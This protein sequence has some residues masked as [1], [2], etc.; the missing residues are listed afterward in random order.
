MNYISNIDTICILLDIE[1]YEESAKE[2]LQFLSDEKEKAKLTAI[3]NASQKHLVT[4]N[5]MNFE[6]RAN[7]TRGYAYILHNSGYSVNISQIKSKIDSFVPI[8]IRISSEYL[9]SNGLTKSWGI[10]Y[11]W[12]I[13]TFGNIISEKVYRV[14]LCSHISDIDLVKDCEINYKGNFKKKNI[15]Y[16]HGEVNA[17]TFGSRNGKSIFCRIYNKYLELQEKNH[18]KWFYEIWENNNMN[19]NNVW[20]IEFELKSEIL[21]SLNI[22]TVSDVSSNSKG[23][24]EYCT[25]QWLIKIDRI[26]E[27]TERC[28]VNTDWL[29]IQN[30][31]NK[32]SYNGL[33]TRS[34]QINSD[35]K[36]LVPNIAGNITSYSARKGNTNIENALLNLHSD[37]KYYF[38]NKNTTFEKEVNNK[39]LI[40]HDCEVSMNE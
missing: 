36:L 20:N 14:D 6:L 21:R 33:L 5:G 3:S 39:M 29:E 28:P 7:G 22:V 26:N 8:Q 34:N 9:W 35:A 25:K 1:N 13:E 31:Y 40:L 30:N 4:L 15:Y 17:I 18:K 16:T 12:I 11:N 19:I 38:H 10:I 32:F 2:T 27:R 23:L 24:W 37:M